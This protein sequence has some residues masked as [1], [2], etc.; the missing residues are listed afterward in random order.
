MRRIFGLWIG[1]VGGFYSCKVY[2]FE[3]CYVGSE[4]RLRVLNVGGL[5]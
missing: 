5:I 4:W 2:T 1:E 3:R